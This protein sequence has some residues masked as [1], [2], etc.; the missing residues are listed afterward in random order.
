M[1][2][3]A[4]PNGP[5]LVFAANTDFLGDHLK[6]NVAIAFQDCVTLYIFQIQVLSIHKARAQTPSNLSVLADYHARHRG[7]AETGDVERAGLGDNAAVQADLGKYRRDRGRQVWIIG[8]DRLATYGAGPGHS[9]RIRAGFTSAR[10]SEQPWNRSIDLG[11]ALQC[12]G[13]PPQLINAQPSRKRSGRPS[14]G[15]RVK[16]LADDVSAAQDGREIVI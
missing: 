7:H 3:E 1:P 9:P 2:G 5:R 11:H 12:A 16:R 15:G 13:R 8:Q 4:N 14:A 6:R 10:A